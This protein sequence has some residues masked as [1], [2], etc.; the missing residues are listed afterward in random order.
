MNKILYS[1]I[2]S[3]FI[4]AFVGCETNG[5]EIG[6]G[7]VRC[8]VSFV[9]DN[10][11][12]RY[13]IYFN[14]EKSM[15]HLTY[16][17]RNSSVKLEVYKTGEKQ[18]DLSQE[19]MLD[20]SGSKNIELIKLVGRNIAISSSVSLEYT[21]F[22]PIIS[23]S[24]PA[25][26]DDLYTVTFNN[27]ELANKEKNYIAEEDLNGTLRIV[28]NADG[29]ILYEQDMTITEGQFSLMQ[30]SDSELLEISDG[31]E[32]D[33]V[34]R[35]YTKI[36]FFYTADAF[37]G[38]D[39][40]QLVVYLMDLD[41]MQFTDPIATIDLEAGKISEYIQIDHDTF[42]QGVVNG[43][44]DLIDEDGNMIVDNMQHLDTYIN[45]ATSDNKFM[46]FRFLD[47]SHQ[48]GDNVQCSPILS[49]PWE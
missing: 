46:T 33:P 23:Y 31:E 4:F 11:Q 5:E 40:L 10:M 1:L 47:P 18:P 45:I 27:E 32:P 20:G 30:L 19:I 17:E 34:S 43:V 39:K 15:N 24:D 14:G 44:Y 9:Q 28:R 7:F 25:T 37:P 6:T 38:H 12:S 29:K 22:T 3:V 2:I 13:E 26:A 42:G 35:Q 41:A 48:G 49:T 16:G 36:R 21:T 8:T